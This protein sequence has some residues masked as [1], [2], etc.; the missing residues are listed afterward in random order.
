MSP[1]SI[2][3]DQ[4]ANAA[5]IRLVDATIAR[6]VEVNFNC[7]VDL[8]EFDGLVGVELLSPRGASLSDIE[9]FVDLRS[10]D[11]GPLKESLKMVPE[12]TMSFSSLTS[13]SQVCV[14]PVTTTTAS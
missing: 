10:E 9:K 1:L 2:A 4:S 11:I 3:I 6:T 13:R 8:D 14:R 12:Y 5:Y 7:F